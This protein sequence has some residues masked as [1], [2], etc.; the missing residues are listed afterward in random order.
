MRAPQ[1]SHD[2]AGSTSIESRGGTIGSDSRGELGRGD[3]TDDVSDEQEEIGD[4]GSSS[5][6]SVDRERGDAI[7]VVQSSQDYA[8]LCSQPSSVRAHF[9]VVED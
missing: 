6:S 2:E 9:G 5:Q 7:I 1:T 4:S 8:L 3:P